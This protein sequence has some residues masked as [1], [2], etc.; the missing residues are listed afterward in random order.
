MFNWDRPLSLNPTFAYIMSIWEIEISESD[1][2]FFD[3]NFAKMMTFFLNMR[4]C[5]NLRGFMKKF[6]FNLGSVPAEM[7]EK[8]EDLNEIYAF[9]N[10][11]KVDSKLVPNMPSKVK[12][13]LQKTRWHMQFNKLDFEDLDYYER[14][15]N[16]KFVYLVSC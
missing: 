11:D 6:D 8:E 5:N 13:Y 16:K 12:L 15:R 9:L 14:A 2:Y 7:G 3:D 10:S 4:L 1:F